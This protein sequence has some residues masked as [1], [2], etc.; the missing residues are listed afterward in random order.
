MKHTKTQQIKAAYKQYL[1]STM[2][3]LEDLYT[4]YS[5]F[6]ARA[7]NYCVDLCNQYNGH[8]LK[9]LGGNCMAFSVGFICEIEDKPA[10]AYITKDYNRYIFLDEI[11]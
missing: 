4:T 7:F 5:V 6:K 11:E 8:T 1:N 10:F 3:S 2:Y 9:I